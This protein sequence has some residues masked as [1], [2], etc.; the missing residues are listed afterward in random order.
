MDEINLKIAEAKDT[1]INEHRFNKRIS[2]K[3]YIN[4]PTLNRELELELLNVG[5]ILNKDHHSNNYYWNYPF[6]WTIFDKDFGLATALA[7]VEEFIND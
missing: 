7:W 3:D 2:P 1:A 5:C 6:R 4:D